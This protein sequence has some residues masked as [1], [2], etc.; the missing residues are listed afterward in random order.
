MASSHTALPHD[1]VEE[2]FVTETESEDPPRPIVKR[3]KV[4]AIVVG[5][6]GL[7]GVASMVLL[8]N[9]G[10]VASS[11]NEFVMLS[12]SSCACTNPPGLDK[13]T[14]CPSGEACDAVSSGKTG[15]CKIMG[16]TCP[17]GSKKRCTNPPTSADAFCPPFQKCS[18]STPFI[19]KGCCE[20]I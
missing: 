15:C 5:V 18:A 4:A 19:L 16:D 2:P 14:W 9:K 13:S 20:D 6:I 8:K 12:S 10:M 11:S 7:V 17:D 3:G 1:D